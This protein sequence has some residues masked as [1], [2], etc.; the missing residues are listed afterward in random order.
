MKQNF[1]PVKPLLSREKFIQEM[2][3]LNKADNP[4][5]VLMLVM[6]WT[7]G[8]PLLTRKLLQD[9]LRSKSRISQGQ[10]A[11]TLQRMVR[12]LV[13]NEFNQDELTL[14]IR[15]FLYTKDVE[16]VLRKAN[17]RVT[18]KEQAY[19]LN[20]Q[21]QLGLSDKQCQFI[22]HKNQ[23]V[24]SKRYIGQSNGN[25]NIV[26]ARRNSEL[27]YS[28]FQVNNPDL[29]LSSSTITVKHSE[30]AFTSQTYVVKNKGF[31][32]KKLLHNKWL[33]LLLSIPFL[34]LCI[35]A[36][37]WSRNNPP[38]ITT[39][40]SIEQQK[41]CVDITSR[42][43]PRMS[44]GEKLLTQE[45]NHLPLSS[46]MALYEGTAAF[47]RCQFS[48]AQAKF[49]ES[50]NLNKNNPETLIYLN[51]AQA[52][53]QE[54][55]KIAV[56]VPLGSQPA[57]AWEILRGV[58]QAQTEINQQ[59]GI[60]N[61]LLLVQVV[62]DD[63]NPE[64]VR[65]LAKQLTAE[66]SILAVVGHND[67]NSSLAAAQI[68]QKQGLV[69][70]SPTSTSTE[71]SNVGNYILRT[72][73]SVAA[74]AK[75]LADHA[76][77]NSLSKITVCSD[78]RDSASNS[79]AQEFISQTIDNGGEIMTIRCDFAWE[80]LD[81]N[82]IVEQAIAENAN[83]LLLIPSVNEIGEA[84]AI[85]KAN[86]QQLPL[87]GNHSLYTGK[88]IEQGKK[89][90]IGMVLPSP[91]LPN[92]TF[93]YDFPQIARQYWGGKVNFRT[94]MAYDAT[95]AIIQGL[96]QSQTRSELQS[97]LTHPDF[98]INGATGEFKFEWGDRSSTVELAHITKEGNF[99]RY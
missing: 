34:T 98:I 97:A 59:G 96:Q 46:T 51:N 25:S 73:P 48:T 89:A 65:Q 63:N 91:W 11:L 86:Q 94:A 68:Y 50:L 42:Q 29:P 52:I 83:A 95:N 60:D 31:S 27:N 32:L 2:Y 35:K 1:Y 53:A 3:R 24:K 22:I 6:K 13:I 84:L 71:L 47:A 69:M 36:W 21:K 9:V 88:T 16:N 67:S 15:K 4:K 93:N 20:S 10:E 14:K 38:S 23:R 33:L 40:L 61:Q 41:L 81:P 7:Q 30:P 55:L 5:L 87:L 57:I 62:N 80:N 8:Q 66:K 49:R 72:I 45:H 75:T 92:A 82:Q 79:F 39:N 76:S 90:V 70:V 56:S 18:Q 37:D 17:G 85:S 74:L 44:L 58:A 26:L 54:H 99:E 28:P 19:L 77:A 12:N 64:I 78:S 43:S